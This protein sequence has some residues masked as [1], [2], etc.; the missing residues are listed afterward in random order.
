[1]EKAVKG[2][3][4]ELIKDPAPHQFSGPNDPMMIYR[5]MI[6]DELVCDTDGRQA[7]EDFKEICDGAIE[8]FGELK[9]FLKGKKQIGDRCT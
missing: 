3:V 1:M 6:N 7:L 9:K 4:F 5:L 2:V 8:F